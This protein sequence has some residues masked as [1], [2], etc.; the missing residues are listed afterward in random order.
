MNFRRVGQVD[1]K[2]ASMPKTS[3]IRPDVSTEH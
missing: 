1:S 3:S 2:E